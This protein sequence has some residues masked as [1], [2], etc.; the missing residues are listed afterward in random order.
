MQGASRGIGLEFARQ[1]ASRD[2]V[3]L[4]LASCR[5]PATAEVLAALGASPKV[6]VM[7]L[8]VE[9]ESSLRDAAALAADH[10]PHLNLLVNAAGMLHTPDGIGPERRLDGLQPGSLARSFAINATGPALVVKHFRTLL[11]KADRPV[12]ANISARVGSIGDNRLGGWYGYRAS[13]AAQNQLTR[14]MAIELG[15][16]PRPVAV[17]ALHPGTVDTDLSRPFQGGVP[18]DKLFSTERAV[19]Q[20]LGIIDGVTR[21][22]SGR[23]FA[24]DGSEIPW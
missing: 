2:D 23:F 5:N 14:C 16:G 11:Q 8:D 20:L 21:E 1:L 12:V 4:V 24:W 6:R 10:T 18:P 13:K 15:R 3:D 9:D 22:Q 17:I 7:R 19:R